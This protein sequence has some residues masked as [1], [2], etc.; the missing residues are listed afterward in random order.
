LAFC[1]GEVININIAVI[2]A[3]GKGSRMKA[4]MNKQFLMLQERPVITYTLDAFNQC[5]EIDEIIVV[6]AP[7]EVEYFKNHI[8]DKFNFTKVK[9]LIAGGLERQQSAYNGIKSISKDCEIILIHDG[10]RP[11][12][13]QQIIIDC[14]H[15][16]KIYGAASAGMPSKDTI[17]LVDEN[18]IVTSTPPRDA[19]WQTQTPQAFKRSLIIDAHEK[20]RDK[21]IIA[22]DDAMLVEM[23]GHQVKMTKAAYENIKITTPEDLSIAE[24]L[25]KV[26]NK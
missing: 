19:V 13:T 7:D 4:G 1:L 2:L 12:V 8:L 11:F 14:I 3:A 20:A 16:A 5:S 15:A 23:M 25:I 21:C 10:A 9:K 18:G 24:Q 17:K 22:T 6:T 26:I